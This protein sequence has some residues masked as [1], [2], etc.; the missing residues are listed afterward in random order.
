[1]TVIDANGSQQTIVVQA[2]GPATDASGTLTAQ[3]SGVYQ[4]VVDA[5]PNRSGFVFQNN[6][7]HVMNITDVGTNPS[8]ISAFEI[9][10]GAFWPPYGYPVPV[11][12]V[13]VTGTLGET[14]AARVW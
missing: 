11:G 13:Y 10:P 6:G 8:V 7:D 1:M 14:F 4:M 3:A 5:D 12:A 2:Q 9:A